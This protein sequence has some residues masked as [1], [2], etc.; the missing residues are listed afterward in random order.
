MKKALAL[1]LTLAMLFALGACSSKPA[2]EP[3]G[4]EAAEPAAEEVTLYVFAAASMTVTLDPTTAIYTV[5]AVL[6]SKRTR[7][8]SFLLTSLSMVR[9]PFTYTANRAREASS[10]AAE[11]SP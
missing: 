11:P 7:V 4:S 8:S 5:C 1:L 3:A 6:L 9:C 2:E 10:P